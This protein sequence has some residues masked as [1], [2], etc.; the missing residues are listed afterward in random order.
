[1]FFNDKV[2]DEEIEKLKSR[3]KELEKLHS[4]DT[5]VLD[6]IANVML[7]FQR[8]LYDLTLKETTLNPTLNKIKES[9]NKA[10]QDNAELADRIVQTLIEYGKAN[11][12]YEVSTDGLSGK[13]GSVLLG[14]K[15]LGTSISELIALMDMTS[16]QLNNEMIQLSSAANTLSESSNSQAASLE[17]TAAALEEVTSTII[18]TSENTIKMGELSNE[19]NKSA[20]TGQELAND[21]FK[22][23][24]GINIEVTAIDEAIVVIDQ[25]A[26]QTNILSLN[27][28]VEAATAGEAGKGFAVVAQEVR[29][30]AG[31][32]AE[33][34]KEIKNIVVKAKEK[35]DSGKN[36]A[37]NMIDGYNSL[38]QN[39]EN[40]LKIIE[41]V[42]SASK[43][44]QQ[45][46]AQIN[47]AVTQ[48]DKTTQQ[49]A[50]AASQINAQSN[51]MKSLS[52]KL[53]DIVAHTSYNKN[54]KEQVSNIDRMFTLNS[55]K[56]DHIK[57]KDVNFKKLDEQTTFQVVGSMQCNLGKWIIEQ[58]NKNKDFTQTANWTKLKEVHLNVHNGV[59]N[60]VN[61]NANNNLQM[62]DDMLDIDKA[63]SEV[64][65]TI[66]QVKKDGC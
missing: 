18:N 2:K 4:N 22:S 24:E 8:G 47:D 59:Q 6:E 12:E 36:I 11:F 3:I 54:A 43:E 53:V 28:A 42:S 9:L 5:I 14:V 27:A 51:S 34:A 37:S 1:M 17:E 66:E 39:I 29:N 19:V 23:M 57:F 33:A 25:I 48:L 64:F 61:N 52:A 31:R 35:A 10:L 65:A 44:Q 13:M 58:E 62:L 21:T 50:S 41:D 15:S 63:I 56:L 30:L 32:S 60:I 46:I 49:N 40:Q 7:K 16:N 45:A 38:T 55:L 26:F 20:I